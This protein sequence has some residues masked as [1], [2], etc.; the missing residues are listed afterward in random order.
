MVFPRKIILFVA[1]LFL[2][3]FSS[4]SYSQIVFKSLPEYKMPTTDS[5]FLGL[6]STR[7]IISLNGTWKVWPASEKSDKA[8]TVKVPSIFKGN[9]E[10][11]FEKQFNLSDYQ[12]THYRMFI[13]ILGLNYT[14]DISVNN[15]IIYR[16]S[17]GAYPFKFDL[18]KDILQSDKE[19]VLTI[20]LFYKLDSENT[21]PLKQRFLF[22]QSFGGILRDVYI[23]LIPNISI[24]ETKL[25]SKLN[26]RHRK[27]EIS[28]Y[29]KIDNREF[30]QLQDS[31]SASDEFSFKVNFISPDSEIHSSK[32]I[33]FSL[34]RNKEKVINQTI[35]INSPALWSPSNPQSYVVNFE[36]WRN[37]QLIDIKRKK[38]EIYSLEVNKDSVTL[39]DE[40]FQFKGVTYI[41][42]FG[43]FGSLADYS[44]MESDI[45][46][47]KNIGFN[48]IRFEKEVPHPY[49][50]YLCE[51]YGL[52][53][54][55]E[56]PLNGVPDE[57]ALDQN[58]ITRS[59]NY[60]SN[61]VKGYQEYPAVAAIGLGGSYLPQLDS[62]ISFIKRL[63]AII[64]KESNFLSF[65]SF[66][67][68]DIPKISDLDL[69]GVEIFDKS[70]KKESAEIQKTQTDLGKGRVLIGSATY[71]VNAGNSNGYVNEYSFEAQAK[72]LEDLLNYSDQNSLSGYFINSAFDYRGDY[73]SLIAGYNNENLYKIGLIGEDRRADRLS[74]NV[75]YSKLHN[76]EKV[77]IPIGS[78]K[79]DAPMSF[80]LFGLI[81]ALIIGVLVNSGKK[82]R[83]DTSRALL[84]PYN[85]FADVRDQR[86]ISGY[87]ST[88]LGIVVSAV[89]GLLL[90]NI[91]FYLRLN[92]VFEKLLL[93][94]GSQ[95]LIDTASYLAWNPLLSIFW[96]SLGSLVFLL[97]L[98]IVIKASSFFVRNR[99][100]F[101]SVYFTV[102]WSF[103]PV[104]L[105]I[106]VGIILYRV[107]N[108]DVANTY[109]YFGLILFALWIFYRLIK[110]IYVIFD[111]NPSGVYFYSIIL[112]IVVLAVIS[113]Y[114]EVN[115]SLT[116][117]VKYVFQQYKIFS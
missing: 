69:Y 31:T 40:G 44:K 29:S 45:S 20:K 86:I 25:E 66:S 51:K 56:L 102:I 5:L 12:I 98:T 60:L 115:S 81:L 6:S 117:Y 37:D 23:S 57:L 83:E 73:S 68:F 9:G 49:Y 48:C 36:L 82:F 53:A 106:P 26:D 3:I 1:I 70:I 27:A 108:A 42:S 79:N 63:C 11:I 62:H 89:S 54:F 105:L 61:F 10:L 111:V 91:L 38:F 65:A 100:Y 104:I 24:T 58:F 87:H 13:N 14:A 55:I 2:L 59:E 71:V 72:F 109:V 15:I 110:G 107:L 96:L 30:S 34:P 114:Y 22:P 74:Y 93:A 103:L 101:S 92:I 16:H 94:F 28:V 113:F 67:G 76:T 95:G 112:I 17:G 33:K 39:N 4:N 41:P 99:V 18:P 21:I 8:V 19:N 35:E 43:E 75:V 47:I 78:K 46:T 77:T 7:K 116:D 52:L 80:I 50:L 84:R 97:L 90:I 64:K 88:I 32:E 85:F